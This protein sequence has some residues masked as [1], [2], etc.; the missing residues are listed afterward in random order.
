MFGHCA[1]YGDCSVDVANVDQLVITKVLS[2]A[3]V[4]PA[5]EQLLPGYL[6]QKFIRVVHN[7]RQLDMLGDIAPFLDLCVAV[8][9]HS[10]LGVYLEGMHEMCCISFHVEIAFLPQVV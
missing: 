4:G 5:I 1:F 10:G 3:M 2:I 7:E 9:H 6:I 8:L